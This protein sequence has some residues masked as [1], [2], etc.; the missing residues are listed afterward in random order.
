MGGTRGSG[1]T[2]TA[3]YDIL[4][5]RKNGARNHG[6]TRLKNKKRHKGGRHGDAG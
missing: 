1:F 4:G 6:C 2:T 3:S 5:C